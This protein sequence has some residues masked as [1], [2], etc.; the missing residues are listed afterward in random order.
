M[1]YLPI[2]LYLQFKYKSLY[3]SISPNYIYAYIYT[4]TH[5]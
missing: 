4:Y 2:K 5:S 3:S 1:Y